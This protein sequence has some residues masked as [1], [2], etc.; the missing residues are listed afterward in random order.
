MADMQENRI[1]MVR[2][3]WFLALNRVVLKVLHFNRKLLAI[4][5]VLMDEAIHLIRIKELEM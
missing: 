1:Q 5:V 2:I 4:L 3:I